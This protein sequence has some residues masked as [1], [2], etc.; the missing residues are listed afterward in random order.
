MIS[1]AVH[2][3][4]QTS[5]KPSTVKTTTAKRSAV[6]LT[7]L[8]IHYTVQWFS[9]HRADCTTVYTCTLSTGHSGSG[10]VKSGFIIVDQSLNVHNM[11]GLRAIRVLIL[12]QVFAVST[13]GKCTCTRRRDVRSS[14]N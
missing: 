4:V 6:S 10:R 13:S 11:F 12:C 3:V 9:R 14:I 2:L 7:S 1:S 8:C 5:A